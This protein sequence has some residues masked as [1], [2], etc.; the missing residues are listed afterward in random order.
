MS[1]RVLVGGLAVAL[2]SVGCGGG[3]PTSPTPRSF[4]QTITGTV[5]SFGTT[6]HNVSVGRN[7][8]AR[9]SVTWTGGG[10]LDLYLTATGCNGYPPTDCQILAAADGFAN[11]EVITRTVTSGEQFKLWVDSFE[12]NARNYTITYTID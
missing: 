2:F 11:P 1:M 9:W 5:S 6:S 8:N 12:A 3:S 7:G 4:T 10:D